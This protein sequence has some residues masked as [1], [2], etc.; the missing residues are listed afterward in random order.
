MEKRYVPL[1][2]ALTT[3]VWGSAFVAIRA[4]VP[5][6]SPTRLASVRFGIAGL[7]LLGVMFRHRRE[8]KLP[9][10][11]W[12]L[13]AIAG[14]LGIGVYHVALNWGM[15]H[16]DA[17]S[18]AFIINTGPLFTALLARWFLHEKMQWG[19]WAGLA[20][21]F[22]GAALI[23]ASRGPLRSSGLWFLAIF[24]AAFLQAAYF[25]I[26]RNFSVTMTS[27]HFTAV[28]VLL[29]AVMLLPFLWA[30]IADLSAAPL[31]AQLWML[32]LGLGPSALGY[33][34]WAYVLKHIPAG[35]ATLFLFLVPLVSLT[36]GFAV[37][38]ERLTLFG[39]V[40]GLVCLAGVALPRLAGLAQRIPATRS[41]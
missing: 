13:L 4:V 1:A 23:A 24:C 3:L 31:R 6:L 37:L 17:A 35:Q 28:T 40:G 7:V 20:L 33:F 10:G 2:I 29:A 14:M 39:L 5:F 12:L 18:A 19:H 16:V 25:V 34:T 38:G 9:A 41:G 8:W 26:A 32:W 11:S 27:L 36:M 21:A 30:G 22:S 15:R